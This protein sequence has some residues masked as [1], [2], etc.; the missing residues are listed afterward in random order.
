MSQ[1]RLFAQTETSELGFGS[2]DLE[3]INK[4]NFGYIGE[5]W[6][7]NPPQKLRAMFDTGST[8]TYFVSK[9]TI[10]NSKYE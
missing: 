2:K 6:L 10:I 3:L 1:N 9:N 7:G 4:Q 8:D 5:I